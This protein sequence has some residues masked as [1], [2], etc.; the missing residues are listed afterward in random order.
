MLQL[1]AADFI[2]S[3]ASLIGKINLFLM[4]QHSGA[5]MAFC[6]IWVSVLNSFHFFFRLCVFAF[7]LCIRTGL[8]LFAL[9]LCAISID[10]QSFHYCHVPLTLQSIPLVYFVDQG[11]LKQCLLFHL[12]G[13]GFTGFYWLF[14]SLRDTLCA[15]NAGKLRA[16][17]SLKRPTPNISV[18]GTKNTW[19]QT[20]VGAF[21]FLFS[22]LRI[23]VRV[24][25][26]PLC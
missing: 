24:S 21:F 11:I 8:F 22:I 3:F 25:P 4:L 18:L 1:L 26:P 10:L 7:I 12:C 19:G 14:S 17:L 5:E 9:L 13:Y 20:F 6:L 23:I 16:P 15:G 2:K